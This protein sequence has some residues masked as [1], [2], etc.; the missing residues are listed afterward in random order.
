MCFSMMENT[1]TQAPS[2][3][4]PISRRTELVR[5]ALSLSPL[6]ALQPIFL[7]SYTILQI[8]G[9]HEI[10]TAEKRYSKHIFRR[11]LMCT[12][13]MKTNLNLIRSERANRGVLGRM[14]LSAACYSVADCLCFNILIYHFHSYPA[15][16]TVY[17]PSPSSVQSISYKGCVKI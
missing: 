13:M 7:M 1:L 6:S 2:L 15:T 4:N 17:L 9:G 14:A 11:S 10:E 12:I 5:D 8:I 3:E 16:S